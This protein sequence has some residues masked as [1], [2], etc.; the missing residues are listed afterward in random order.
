MRPDTGRAGPGTAKVA[1]RSGARH[2]PDQPPAKAASLGFSVDGRA[3]GGR[4]H[5]DDP[6]HFMV[7]VARTMGALHRAASARERGER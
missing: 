5:L 4:K 7:Q 1:A 2:P 6:E 3:D